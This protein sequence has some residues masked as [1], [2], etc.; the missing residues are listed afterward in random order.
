MVLSEVVLNNMNALQRVRCEVK[1]AQRPRISNTN[2][3]IW[4][5]PA[6]CPLMDRRWQQKTGRMQCQRSSDMRPARCQPLSAHLGPLKWVGTVLAGGQ[7]LTH[8][9]TNNQ[10]E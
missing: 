8:M 6:E 7:Q 1:T 10:Q 3:L 4:P 2:L 5:P 9:H